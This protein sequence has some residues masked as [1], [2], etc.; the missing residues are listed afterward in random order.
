MLA[1]VVDRGALGKVIA[2][3]FAAA[4]VLTIAFTSG[5]LLVESKD[6]RR[7]SAAARLVGV[8]AFGLCLGLVAIGIDVVLTTK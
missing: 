3:S 1:T 4:L 5:V 7:P 6:G 8:A 2:Y